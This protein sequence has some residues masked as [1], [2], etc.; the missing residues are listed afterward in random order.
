LARIELRYWPDALACGI[1]LSPEIVRQ[2]ETLARMPL[3]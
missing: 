3:R 2:E 1:R